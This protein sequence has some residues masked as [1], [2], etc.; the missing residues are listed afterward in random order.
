[1]ST[2][3]AKIPHM[4]GSITSCTQDGVKVNTNLEFLFLCIT[5]PPAL[6]LMIAS[7]G[8]AAVMDIIS[9]VE[10]ELLSGISSH[11]GNLGI[12]LSAVGW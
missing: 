12:A 7:M 4:Y 8:K 6:V 1:M 2:N 3:V 5:E 9:S 11:C 10:I